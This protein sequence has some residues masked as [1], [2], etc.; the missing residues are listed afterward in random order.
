M[1]TISAA[2]RIR[3]DLVSGTCRLFPRIGLIAQRNPYEIFP[4][5]RSVIHK[6]WRLRIRP[7]IVSCTVS[8]F[9]DLPYETRLLVRQERAEKDKILIG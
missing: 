2:I 1:T 4:P 7:D 3:P 6:A 9:P 8:T 5:F